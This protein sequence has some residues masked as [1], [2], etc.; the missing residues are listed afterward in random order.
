[1]NPPFAAP[2]HRQSFDRFL[3]ESL[4]ELLSARVPL[5]SYRVEE[6][7]GDTCRLHVAVG[8]AGRSV[9][10]EIN[11]I[12][13]P[14][15]SGVFHLDGGDY[16]V[17]PLA[18]LSRLDTADV[19]C[20]GE[21]MRDHIDQRLGEAPADIEWTADLLRR[22]LPVDAW[23]RE[24]VLGGQ[25]LDQVNWLARISHLR[26]LRVANMEDVFDPSQVGLTCM[27]ETPEG[28]NCGRL[29]RIAVGATIRDG[30]VVAVDGSPRRMLGAVA[31]VV[32]L[33]EH[34]DPNRQLMGVNM[35]RQWIVPPDPEPALVR[36]G[37]E[38][39]VAGFW[40]GRNLLTAFTSMDPDT[41]ED[42]I[43]ISRTA[44]GRLGHRRPLEVGDKLSNRHGTKGTI[45]RI[46]PDERM[47]H[48]P[49]GAAVEIV[50]NFVGLHTRMNF[51]Q[52][53]EAVLGRI[54]RAQG[55][56]F[57]SPPFD[58]PAEEE[59][60]RLLAAHGM[61]ESGMVRLLDGRAGP[62]FERPTT[63]GWVYWGKTHHLAAD[64]IQVCLDSPGQNGQR[65]GELEY[66]ALRDIGATQTI[67]D[68]FSTRNADRTDAAA[69]AAQIASGSAEPPAPPTPTFAQLTQRLALAGIR[70]RFDGSA[71][72]FSFHDQADGTPLA[73]P[74]P[75][76]W[77][78]ERTLTHIGQTQSPGPQYQ[79]VQQANQRLA[80]AIQS[81]A[82]AR[83]IEE[84][85][86]A[87]HRHLSAWLDAL[88]GPEQLRLASR[89][90][91]SGRAVLS[92]GPEFALDRIGLSDQIAWALFGPM[93]SAQVGHRAVE[94]RTPV[95]SQALDQ[96][97]AASWVILHRAPAIWPASLLA[98]HPVR[99]ADHVVRIPLQA[100]MLLN[101]DFD[102]DQVGIHL[103]VT[104]A[105][106]REAADKLSI[107]GHLRRDPSLLRWLMPTHA[108][109]WGLAKLS[110]DDAGRQQLAGLLGPLP[111]GLLDRS[112]LESLLRPRL[113][114][115]GEQA[116]LAL[117][118]DLARLGFEAA[119]A[120]GATLGPFPDADVA[121]PARPQSDVPEEWQAWF[122]QC[123]AAVS[124]LADYD[125]PQHGAQVLLVRSGA[126][127][128][129]VQLTTLI[130]PRTV[131]SRQG[132][133]QIARRSLTDGLSASEMAD[134]A[135]HARRAL[136]SV[137]AGVGMTR[138]AYGLREP[139][140][141]S[142]LGVLARA[143]RDPRPGLVFARA[144]LAGE[145][146]PL[147]DVDARLLVGIV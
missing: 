117:L 14:D 68:T 48:M 65:M 133:R 62:P 59:I 32:P 70:M 106:Q 130:S 102:G 139:S 131:F 138:A 44:A 11:G 6:S 115:G 47:P 10:V 53:R 91:F 34:N 72:H 55:T 36:A 119:R 5:E 122:D 57:I 75:H 99:I 21:Q 147:D 2:W 69:L 113:T 124:R 56:P 45:T 127:G 126:R 123:T 95:A 30:R 110:L 61:D 18:S 83:M 108:A 3:H 24:V 4:P 80:R 42:G 13:R 104:P 118:A 66:T 15:E 49:D 87:L 94:E 89:A 76:P 1:M 90:M 128:N 93:L 78:A 98:F 84:G 132:Q 82:P 7:S 137:D 107:A 39:D 63:V 116:M 12:S 136:A 54:A 101:G 29:L 141:V 86:A 38:P 26:G 74:L 46:L 40:C 22:W 64:K 105:A 20:V 33:L 135:I 51:G 67:M 52:V 96:L 92:A 41:H 112:A 129:P 16:V 140:P 144:A 145:S 134:R 79:Q 121:L 77:A 31:F 28:P 97:M 60:R 142:G 23:V 58:G 100:L 17:L 85:Q 35:M 27:V 8:S 73:A 143:M 109:M 50:F 114:S 9:D 37:D 43:V 125:H 120:S 88:V 146:D 111:A 25:V 103:P 71:V 81:G 19:R